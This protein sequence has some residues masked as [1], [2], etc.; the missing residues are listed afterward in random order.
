[1][2]CYDYSLKNVYS[3]I[4]LIFQ[5]VSIHKEKYA[6]ESVIILV[7]TFFINSSIVIFAQ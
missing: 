6:N 1:M 7:N 2:L 5:I 3:I 4:I